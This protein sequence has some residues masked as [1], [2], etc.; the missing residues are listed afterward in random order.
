MIMTNEAIATTN[1]CCRATASE[2]PVA[3]EDRRSVTPAVD[4]YET[5]DGLVVLADLPG[6]APDGVEVKVDGDLLTIVG[7]T[8]PAAPAETPEPGH[9]EFGLA[10]YHRQFRLHR[11]VDPE[12]ITAGLTQGV[13]RVFLPHREETKPRQIPVQA[14]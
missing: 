2:A 14:G 10:D 6:V 4:I 9:R 3:R 7:R 5:A 13:L 11:Q 1:D 8:A 12:R